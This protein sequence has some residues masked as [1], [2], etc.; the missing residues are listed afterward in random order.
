MILDKLRPGGTLAINAIHL[1]PIPQMDY[2]RIY[3]E[4][5]LRSVANLTRQDGREF[6]ALAAQIPIEAQVTSYPLTDANQA[7]AD[8]KHSR[9]DGAAVL[10]L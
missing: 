8:L 1:S 6:L 7:L 10:T 9:I 3:G 2:E 4:R 5:T